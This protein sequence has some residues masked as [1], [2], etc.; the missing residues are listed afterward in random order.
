MR[1]LTFISLVNL[2]EKLLS[3]SF[4]LWVSVFVWMV[5]HT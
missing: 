4:Q 2:V 3:L 5:E 1:F